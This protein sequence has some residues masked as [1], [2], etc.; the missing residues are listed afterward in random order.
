MRKSALGKGKEES[1]S[2]APEER[3]TCFIPAAGDPMAERRVM[4]EK[5]QQTRSKRDPG[6]DQVGLLNPFNMLVFLLEGN[7]KS[8]KSLSRRLL[9]YE[10]LR[11]LLGCHI[12]EI[13]RRGDKD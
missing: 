5:L 10:L 7:G 9:C 6:P 13:N 3:H 8:L 12:A 2:R 4:V 11:I 1:R